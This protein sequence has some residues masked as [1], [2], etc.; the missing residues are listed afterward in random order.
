[1]ALEDEETPGRQA[2]AA[3]A[4]AERRVAQIEALQQEN[5][6]GK[7]D[8]EEDDEVLRLRER[9]HELKAEVKRKHEQRNELR[10]ELSEMG[11]VL[12]RGNFVGRP[13]K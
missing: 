6:S 9:V 3:E 7:R 12:K 11:V 8:S 4:E 10:R 1:M 2:D 13:M 5:P